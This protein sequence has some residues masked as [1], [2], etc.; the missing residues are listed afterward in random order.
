M[1]ALYIPKAKNGGLKSVCV[2]KYN[3]GDGNGP[4]FW[5]NGVK[6]CSAFGSH[7]ES[8]EGINGN[9]TTVKACYTP[10][11]DTAETCNSSGY[12]SCNRVICTPAAANVICA[13]Y[14][15]QGI[16]AWRLPTTS[17][18]LAWGS[19]S[20]IYKTGLDLCTVGGFGGTKRCT[21]VNN[22]RGSQAWGCRPY[23]VAVQ[24][25]GCVS[26]GDS[27][28][29]SSCVGSTRSVRCVSDYVKIK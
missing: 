19:D 3:A 9:E 6:G 24:G 26:G 4:S 27:S 1:N 17:E 11:Y 25:N 7:D 15:P 12:S 29:S 21:Y 16:G 14:N 20:A 22:C 10:V 28:F 5:A 8:C 13:N 23:Q 2:T 18:V